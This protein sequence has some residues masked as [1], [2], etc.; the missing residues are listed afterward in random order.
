MI[1][2]TLLW[3]CGISDVWVNQLNVG[4]KF[5]NW[6]WNEKGLLVSVEVVRLGELFDEGAAAPG[7]GARG[8]G[9]GGGWHG[10]E[11]HGSRSRSQARLRPAA[12]LAPYAPLPPPLLRTLP[13]I[14]IGTINLIFPLRQQPPRFRPSI[15]IRVRRRRA[16]V[17]FNFRRSATS[18]ILG[19]VAPMDYRYFVIVRDVSSGCVI[20]YFT[21]R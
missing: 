7:G 21:E 6:A 14:R 16:F 9:R 8:A 17:T 18:C 15:E 3:E 20:L 11:W 2:H 19:R 12:P 10:A 1:T 5:R 13:Q 4:K